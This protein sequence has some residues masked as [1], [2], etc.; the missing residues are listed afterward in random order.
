MSVGPVLQ[1][2]PF[3]EGKKANGARM[4]ATKHTTGR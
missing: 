1:G 4:L 3:H 2:T